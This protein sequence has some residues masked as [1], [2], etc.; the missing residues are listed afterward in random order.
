MIDIRN[1][2]NCCGC[3]ACSEICP[4][5]CISMI[6]DKEGFLYPKINIDLC[7]DCGL[8]ERTCPI[9]QNKEQNKPDT[10]LAAINKD[11]NIRKASSSGGIFTALAELIIE[12]GG[13]VF[14]ARY[15]EEG[16]IFHCYSDNVEGIAKFRGSKYVQSDMGDC[17]KQCESFLNDGREV[18]F[19]GTPCQIAG[20]K[21]FLRKEYANLLTVDVI[22]HGVP[23]PGV[24]E[25]YI[26]QIRPKG[27]A[28]ENTVL[29]LKDKPYVKGLSFRDKRTGWRKFGFAVYYGATKGSDENSVLP[30]RSELSFYEIFHENFFLRGFLQNLY[31][32]PSCHQCQ[33]R[34]FYSC[35]D[36]TIA[37]FWGVER[38][39]KDLDDDKGTS[40]VLIKSSRAKKVLSDLAKSQILSKIV[41]EKDYEKAFRG[42]QSLFV[43]D[44][45]SKN[46]SEFFNEFISNPDLVIDLI[47]K[48]TSF[49]NK[50]KK[51]YQLDHLLLKLGLY[52]IIK[53]LISLLRKIR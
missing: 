32:R 19:T 33:F 34:N 37:D 24:W 8:C 45:P 46:R 52:N 22:C 10:V 17:F 25:E 48:Y 28:G 50:E 40:L 31:L 39:F 9:I 42:N 26:K 29:S 5:S 20:L 4:K 30:S 16:R 3:S 6:R 2:E 7:I 21:K 43:D 13:V 14:G 11:K 12:K 18:L 49:S 38:V 47:N 23:S 36:I 27:V 44:L 15:N 41:D 51:K 35:S 1:K 53:D